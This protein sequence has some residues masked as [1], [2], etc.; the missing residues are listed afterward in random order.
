MVVKSCWNA[1]KESLDRKFLEPGWKL[2]WGNALIQSVIVKLES[3]PGPNNGG[4][5]LKSAF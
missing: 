5:D 1:T 3:Q 2:L 4:K